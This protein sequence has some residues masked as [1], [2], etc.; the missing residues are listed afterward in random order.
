MDILFI[1]VSLILAICYW[2]RE[3]EHKQELQDSYEKGYK[4]GLYEN[5][6][7]FSED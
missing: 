2:M 5:V 6:V 7:K 3:Q 1:V 4:K